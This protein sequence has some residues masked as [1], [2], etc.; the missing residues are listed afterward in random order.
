MKFNGQTILNAEHTSDMQ[1]HAIAK[2]TQKLGPQ[3]CKESF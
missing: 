1:L 3:S 2:W